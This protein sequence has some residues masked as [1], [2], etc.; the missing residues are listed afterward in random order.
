MMKNPATT[1]NLPIQKPQI[2][3]FTIP[4]SAYIHIPFCRRRC[5]Y[6]DFPIS[7]VG[8]KIRGETSGTIEQYVEMLSQ[9]IEITPNLGKPLQTVFFGGGTPS[10]LSVE[11]VNRLLARIEKKFGIATNAEISM[12][13]DPGTFDLGRLKGYRN[14]GIN[15][16][17]VG[18]QA[19]QDELLKICGRSHT[20]SDIFAAVQLIHQVDFPEFSLDLISGLPNQTL[21][22]WQTSLETAVALLTTHISVYDLTIEPM[23]PFGRQF[24]PGSQPLPTDETTVQMYKLAQKVLNN[25]GYQHYEISNYAQPGHQCRHNRVYWQN[26]SYYGFGM[27]AASYVGGRRF[28]RPRTRREYYEWVTSGAKIECEPVSSNDILL[29]TLMLGLRLEEGLDLTVLIDNFGK[30]I[31][32][33][34]WRCLQPYYQQGLVKVVDINQFNWKGENRDRVPYQGKISLTDPEGFLVSNTIL[35]DLFEQL[36]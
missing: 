14:A 11:Q 24:K 20:G 25:A 22:Q 29:E 7:V 16:I 33:K 18:V 8:D 26:Q 6:C 13:I 34:I 28:T 5:Y 36:D 1:D 31:L 3:N 27:G 2:T 4:T 21:S 32:H 17:S 10:L 23:T 9:E 12:E 15:R 30:E 19:F 35:A